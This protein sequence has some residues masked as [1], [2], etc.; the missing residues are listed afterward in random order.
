MLTRLNIQLIMIVLDQ[1]QTS[2]IALIDSVNRPLW[3]AVRMSKR[4][5]MV[6]QNAAQEKLDTVHSRPL[7]F[8]KS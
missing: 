5:L 7:L 4:E 6:P 8:A 3:V 2:S 1:N